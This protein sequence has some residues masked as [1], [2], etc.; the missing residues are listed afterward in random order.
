MNDISSS[1]THA[2]HVPVPQ[3]DT[4]FDPHLFAPCKCQLIGLQWLI[5]HTIHIRNIPNWNKTIKIIVFRLLLYSFFGNVILLWSQQKH[6]NSQTLCIFKSRVNYPILRLTKLHQVLSK[7]M[8]WNHNLEKSTSY[9]Y[10]AVNG[11]SS[12]NVSFNILIKACI[13]ACV[14]DAGYDAVSHACM[15]LA[16]LCKRHG[17]INII[18]R[19]SF[20]IDL[21]VW[22]KH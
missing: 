14:H 6:K 12:N 19:F 3:L 16:C 20:K 10:N 4:E 9:S 18:S 21:S 1:K 8:T 11:Y 5:Y 17:V 2:V 13:L 7:S 15:S 22:K